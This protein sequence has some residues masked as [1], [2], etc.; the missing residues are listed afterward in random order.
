MSS[1]SSPVAAI[2]DD[3]YDGDTDIFQNLDL[4]IRLGLISIRTTQMHTQKSVDVLVE[5]IQC[6]TKLT[7]L[8][9]CGYNM[10]EDAMKQFIEA[11]Q[12]TRSVTKLKLEYTGM[13]RLIPLLIQNNIQLVSLDVAGHAMNY[14]RASHLENYIEHATRM[15]SLDLS[16]NR[17]DDSD[18]TT[19]S[20]ALKNN[21][22][23]TK[24]NLSNI[25]SF[26]TMG[27]I[28]LSNT[29]KHKRKITDIN[30]SGNVI[31]SNDAAALAD[32][33]KHNEVITTLSLVGCR[34]SDEQARLLANA[35][36]YNVAIREV[37]L[38]YNSIGDDGA[39][40]LADAIQENKN[41]TALDLHFNG[42]I[43][44][45]GGVAL[46][47]AIRHNKNMIRLG[48]Y[49]NVPTYPYIRATLTEICASNKARM[50]H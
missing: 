29:L 42:R 8:T 2:V 4:G 23:L 18:M 6:S 30:L 1:S 31:R 37:D 49:F 5:T 38:S 28:S 27:C 15:Q 9:L 7:E 34:L 20:H 40:A 43:D 47:G 24:V 11:M 45:R 33:F 17:I 35:F 25:N 10:D 21:N 36:K 39:I 41:I 14:E 50:P 26:G 19:L 13:S 32:A 3:S 46:I 12:Y 44:H 22:T 16:N 48:F